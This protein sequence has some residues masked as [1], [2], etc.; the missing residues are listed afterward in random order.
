MTIF[1]LKTKSIL[2]GI[3]LTGGVL[4]AT[5]SAT[6]TS[7]AQSRPEYDLTMGV[8]TSPTDVY[9]EMTKLIP[10]RISAATDG[11]VSVTLSSSLVA[12][13]QIASAVRD[14]RVPIV[15]ATHAYIA[16]EE[17][18]IS[19][20]SLPG[21][22]NN[23]E[24]YEATRKAFWRDDVAQFWKEKW[25]AEMLAD[26]PYCPVVLFSREPIQTVD[27][28]K[29]KRVRIFDPS[30]AALM[31]S[32]GA[33]PVP[34]PTTE[35]TPALER[36]VIDAVLTSIC[37]GAA[38]ELA[39]VA[40][41]V[42]EWEMAPITGWAILV[43]AEIWEEM[44]ED[45]RSDIQSAMSEIEAEAFSTYGTY[46]ERAK[47]SIRSLGSEIWEAPEELKQQV[48][49]KEL[50]DGAYDAWYARAKEAGFDGPAYIAKVR[51]ALGK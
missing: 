3:A 39:R 50:T 1:S 24:E 13:N 41:H 14:G 16:A 28:F 15:A 30:S 32:L 43:N 42:Q 44:P 51:N 25:N 31:N 5:L 12:A 4:A 29:G 48:R 11:R 46:V 34:M 27:A 49:T 45:L 10:E 18:R 6:V 17:P 19:I 26:G 9:D 40:P 37:A 36:G 20:F 21:L 8:M 35:V 33:V 23:I 38:F 2:S 22:I 7:S 47:A